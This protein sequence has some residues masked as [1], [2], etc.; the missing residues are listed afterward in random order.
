MYNTVRLLGYQIDTRFVVGVV[1]VLPADLLPHVLL[2][3]QLEYVLVEI[4]LKRLVGVVDTQ[5]F[6]TV[7]CKVLR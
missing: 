5:L 7:R 3:F 6:E 2:L 4:E 1:D